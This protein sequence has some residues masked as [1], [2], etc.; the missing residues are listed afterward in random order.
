M[1]WQ[2]AQAIDAGRP[3]AEWPSGRPVI[4]TTPEPYSDWGIDII[5]A[6]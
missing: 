6:T 1:G 4:T 5:I 3:T 2:G